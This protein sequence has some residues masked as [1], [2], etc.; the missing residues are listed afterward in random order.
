MKELLKNK[1]FAFLL[2]AVIFAI[3]LEIVS[4]LN[5]HFPLWI[6]IPFFSVICIG[7]GHKTIWSGIKNLIKLN[8]KSIN[9][10]M[11]LAVCGAFYLGQYPEAAIVIVLFT[12]GEYMEDYGIK[13]SKSAIE[14]LI[15]NSPKT[16]NVK[17]SGELPVEKVKKGDIVIIKPG[18]QIPLD[19]KI[20]VGTSYV[21]E[22]TITG[23]P[24][25]VDKRKDDPVYAGTINKGG[26]FEFEVT[27]LSNDSTLSKIIDL[28]FK[29]AG[30]RAETQRFINKFSSFYTPSILVITFLILVIPVFIFNAEFNEWLLMSLTLLVISCP[31]ALVISTPVSIYSALGNASSKGILIKGGKYLEEIGKIE[32]IAL[33]KTRTITLGKPIVSDIIPFNG[34]SKQDLLACA[35][36]FEVFS[37]HPLAQSIVEEAEK[38]NI[39]LH[40]VVNFESISGKGVKGDCIVC[41]SKPHFLGSLKYITENHNISN[42]ILNE[43]E[44]LQKKGKTAL[45]LSS[46]LSVEGI[47]AVTDKIKDNSID[48][49]SQIKEL[50]VIP[51]MMTGDNEYA[52]KY[53]ADIVGIKDIRS[54]LLPDGKVKE[55][56]KIN[57]QYHY[58]A[59]VGDGINDAP[60]LANATIGIAMGAA[61][62]DIAIETADIV[63]MNDNLSLIPYLIKLSRHTISRIK[64]NTLFA[65]STKFIFIIL[66]VLGLSNLIMAIFADVGVTIIV[67]LNSLRIMKFK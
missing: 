3:I 28:T 56:T 61:G 27:K 5:F 50:G 19:G 59:M 15:N 20:I 41:S 52:A 47:I 18:D 57:F 45:I 36:G 48:A 53:I 31:C 44:F 37:E 11:F 62:S 7:I 33:D 49:V 66:A 40:Q 14:S 24:I 51:I 32:A 64:F 42:D 35:A 55:I 63:L 8:F 43:V 9:T 1:K 21:D 29:S 26:Y 10:L 54:Q 25:P 38:N 67:I 39:D 22:S 65:I 12:L 30:K 6:E 16:A 46:G 2:L 58:V 17:L 34:F 60:A 4:L 13:K 23:E